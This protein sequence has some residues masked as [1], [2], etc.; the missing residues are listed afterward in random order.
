[1]D[2]ELNDSEI[3]K[4]AKIIMNISGGM[5][6]KEGGNSQPEICIPFDEKII[7]N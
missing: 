4:D 5:C 3:K 1:M 2:I 6:E 7:I